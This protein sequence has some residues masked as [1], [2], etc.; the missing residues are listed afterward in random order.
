[1]NR[2]VL[3]GNGFDLA[4]GLETS[5]KNFID[6]YWGYRVLLM[7]QETTSISKD[8][9]CSF[10]RKDGQNWHTYAFYNFHLSCRNLPGFEHLAISNKEIIDSI[11]TDPNNVIT[12][13]SPF[14]ERII[15]SIETKKWVD[16]ENEYYNLL[17]EYSV[18]NPSESKLKELNEQLS[19]LQDL[20]LRYLTRINNEAEVNNLTRKMIYSPIKPNDI[21]VEWQDK[22]N[23]Y[24]KWCFE[25]DKEKWR[26]KMVN[27][28]D[29][30]SLAD[31]DDYCEG[32]KLPR[33]FMLPDDI[34]LLSF[35]YTNTAR[36]YLKPGFRINY[37]HGELENPKS[38]IFG[39]G[40]ELDENFKKIKEL[41]NSECRKNIKSI[42]YL[43]AAN[44]REMLQ[45]IESAP[46]QVFIMGHSCGNSDRTL[47][48]TLFE[49]KNCISIKPYYH[50]WED[51]DDY[52]DIVQNISRNFKDMKKMRDRVV[53]KTY[54][55]PLAQKKE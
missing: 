44:Y 11:I 20:L 52:F 28:G 14:F 4:H 47:L 53:N 12:K 39:Y 8:C 3:I 15:Y 49:H 33:P 25:Q 35:N 43:E 36:K 21:A 51:G 2:L 19:Y 26:N 40:D 31:I 27:Y 46:F 9:L 13:F 7:S 41:D 34:M 48:N 42:K 37:I 17:K 5:Y 6:A 1:M 38:V 18:D 32:K 30:L 10:E 22:F 50:K 29:E 54:C 45:F 23:E 16:I 55:E 24:I